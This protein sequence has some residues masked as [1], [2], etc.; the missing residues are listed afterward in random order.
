MTT[1]ADILSAAMVQ[2]DDVRL[3]EQLS[4]SPAQFYRRMSLIV[5]QAFPLLSRP[6]EL[7]SFLKSGMKNPAFDD[8]EW[9]STGESAGGETAVETGKTGFE[10]CSVVLRVPQDNGTVM[11]VPYPDAQY[12]A[13]SGVVTFP[14]QA[15]AGISYDIDFYSD[16]AFPTLTETQTRLFALAVAVVWDERFSRNWLAMFPKIKDENFETVNEANYTEKITKRLH[17]NRISFNDELRAY[18]QQC[19]YTATVRSGANRVILI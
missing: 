16:G 15:G 19:A 5:K 14:R 6:P 12:D 1:W 10:L 7:L 17:D 11:Y 2:I 8:A 18:E 13:E 3:Q 9:T 4:V